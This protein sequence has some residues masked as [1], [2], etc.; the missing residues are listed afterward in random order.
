IADVL[1][2]ETD[3]VKALSGHLEWLG[4]EQ[5][6]LERQ[7]T[8]VKRTIE[9]LKGGGNHMAE[10]M[11]DGFDHTQY[12]EEV[13]ERWGKDAYAA[14]DSWWRGMSADQKRDWKQ[15]SEQL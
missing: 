15:R 2:H 13:E 8:S 6:R 14:S 7:M 11:F 12:K 5:L 3:A 1:R 10:D 4:Q 9:E